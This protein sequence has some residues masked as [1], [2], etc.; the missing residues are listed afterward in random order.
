MDPFILILDIYSLNVTINILP[1][2]N[3]TD[4]LFYVGSNVTLQCDFNNDAVQ[5]YYNDKWIGYILA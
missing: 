4:G 3:I 2:E 5:W 1:F